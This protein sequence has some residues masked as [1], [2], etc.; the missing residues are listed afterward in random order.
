MCLGARRATHF[1]CLSEFDLLVSLA[2]CL[3]CQHGRTDPDSLVSTIR[4][5]ALELPSPS[6]LRTLR[7]WL[8]RYCVAAP[9][10][11]QKTIKRV[12]FMFDLSVVVLSPVPVVVALLVL[13]CNLLL[14]WLLLIA[15]D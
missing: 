12:Y 14:A 2:M 11:Y 4:C 15:D 9:A 5:V 10:K 3:V 8:L 7:G 1:L 13:C 6:W